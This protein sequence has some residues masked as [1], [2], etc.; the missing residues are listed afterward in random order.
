[1]R[2]HVVEDVAELIAMHASEPW[3]VRVTEK[4]EAV[5]LDRWRAHLDDCAVLGLWCSPRRIPLLVGDLM[6][7]ARSL[8]FGRLLGPLV[9]ERTVRPY[10]ESGMRVIER[11]V[12]MRLD[13]SALAPASAKE[14]AVA[15]VDVRAASEADLSALLAVDA[16]CFEPFW[17][18]DLRLLS[19][20]MRADRV[21]V[22][23]KDGAI[24]GYTLA[25]VRG[26]DGSLG[27][28]AVVPEMRRRGIGGLLTSEAVEWMA[29]RGARTVILSTQV[30]NLSARSLYREQ[31]FRDLPGLLVAC[32]SAPLCS[33]VV[34]G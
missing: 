21:A 32:A 6:E 16:R 14:H 31:G 5:V 18:Y 10:L 22:V 19:R 9:P 3:R 29:E 23:E 11:I 28:L 8:G 1:V 12:A 13:A 17:R 26:G 30:D 20:L 24:I 2:S 4:G 27:R 33:S 34:E 15:G 7:V 25:T